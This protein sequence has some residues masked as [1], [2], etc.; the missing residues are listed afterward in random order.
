MS[1]ALGIPL[2]TNIYKT[3]QPKGRNAEMFKNKSNKNNKRLQQSTR[4]REIF[5]IIQEFLRDRLLRC[6]VMS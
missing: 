4:V 3:N 1:F 2:H 6:T 5:E